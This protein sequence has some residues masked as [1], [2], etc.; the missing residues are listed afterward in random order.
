MTAYLKTNMANE[1]GRHP[2]NEGHRAR[3]RERL[4]RNAPDLADYEVLELLLGYALIRRDTKPLARELLSRFGSI[5]GALDARHD[6]LRAVPGF[7]PGLMNLWLV[8]REIMARHALSPLQRR[9]VLATPAS[10]AQIARARLSGCTH[11][12]A[13]LALVDTRN[14]L[15]AWQ[16]LREGGIDSVAVQPRDILALALACNAS[17]IILIH[18]HPGGNAEPSLSDIQL[19]SELENL[20]PHMGMRFLD[21]VIITDGDCY[22]MAERRLV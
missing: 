13:W 19:T 6:E 15:I 12:E 20:A 10:V 22:S 5:R 16:R 1:S 8:M 11:E 3:L 9:E 21:H 2:A 18:N 14:R 7:G 4:A 17:G